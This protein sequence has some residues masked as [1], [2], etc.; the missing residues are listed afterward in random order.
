[1]NTDGRGLGRVFVLS[2][3]S[4]ERGCW[5]ALWEWHYSRRPILTESKDKLIYWVYLKWLSNVWTALGSSQA[6]KDREKIALIYPFLARDTSLTMQFRNS[7][8]LSVL[9]FRYLNPLSFLLLVHFKKIHVIIPVSELTLAQ[10]C[11]EKS[12]ISTLIKQGIMLIATLLCPFFPAQ[13]LHKETGKDANLIF[14]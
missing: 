12:L 13:S 14:I 1:M 8:R 4:F 3:N 11:K 5:A 10:C 9:S 2:V 7:F 6:S